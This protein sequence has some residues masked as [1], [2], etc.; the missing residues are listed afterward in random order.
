MNTIN[1]EKIVKELIEN[2]IVGKS[3]YVANTH[4]GSTESTILE[5]KDDCKKIAVKI[6]KHCIVKKATSF[7]L[8]YNNVDF[9]PNLLFVSHDK[10]FFAYDFLENE[11]FHAK[12]LYAKTV[13]K[14]IDQVINKYIQSTDNFWGNFEWPKVSL[15]DFLQEEISWR[16]STL[17][18][19]LGKN[20]FT[21]IETLV[22]KIFSNFSQ[23]PYL[24]HGDLG[25]HNIIVKD[26]KIS[27]V[28]D[29]F[30]TNSIPVLELF[31][32]I[33]SRP[34]S[35]SIEDINNFFQKIKNKSGIRKSDLPDLYRIIL[36]IRIGTCSKYHPEDLPRYIA[37][38]KG[39]SQNG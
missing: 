26:R 1:K 33:C 32:L 8:I 22:K 18:K 38:Y 21:K 35:F 31:Y 4:K 14:I 2:K 16:K 25:A 28:I 6:E 9:F 34:H 12:N 39:P 19:I 20:E 11:L 27:G 24:V 15:K 3:A 29:P 37:L 17:D 23:K 10:S 30:V 7:L 13:L 5:I 36:Y